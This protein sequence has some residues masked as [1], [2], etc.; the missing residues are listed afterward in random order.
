M[1]LI[2]LTGGIG[3]GK[4]TIA[5]R[6]RDLGAH[7]IDADQ[8]ARDVVAPGTQALSAICA[9]FGSDMVG[10][11]G[12]LNR[13]ALARVVF[14]SP[15]KLAQLNSIVHP[16]VRDETLSRIQAIVDRQ[17]DAVIVY[18]VPLLVESE[19]SY[20]FDHIIV[21][22]APADVR[23]DRL[24]QLRGMTEQEAR[25]R[26]ARQASDDERLARAD[27]IIETG[28]SLEST[29]QSVDTFWESLKSARA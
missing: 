3:A 1:M 23:L 24:M 2:G 28:G 11:D 18:D 6:L 10:V 8:V 20:E 29:L 9:T 27:T 16:A 22:H 4:S 13:P 15:D 21:A 26:I 17:P 12:A 14:E 5:A 19:N 25:Q 7:V